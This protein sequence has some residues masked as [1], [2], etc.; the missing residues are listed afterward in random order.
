LQVLHG[1]SDLV[2]HRCDQFITKTMF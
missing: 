1:L 2:R